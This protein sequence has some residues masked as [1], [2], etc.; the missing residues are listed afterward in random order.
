MAYHGTVSVRSGHMTLP[1]TP[2]DTEPD[3]RQAALG[4]LLQVLR[5]HGLVA[6]MLTDRIRVSQPRTPAIEIDIRCAPRASC[7]GELWFFADGGRPIAAADQFHEAIPAIKGL[8]AVR[9]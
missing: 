4:Q 3:E 6:D 1:A 7:D 8:T 2:D 5:G 9:L